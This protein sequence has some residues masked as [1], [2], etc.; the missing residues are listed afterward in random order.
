MNPFEILGIT[1]NATSEQIKKAFMQKAREKFPGAD[2]DDPAATEEYNKVIEAYKMLSDP[3]LRP[4]DDAEFSDEWTEETYFSESV[5]QLDGTY[6][7]D[8]G[9]ANGTV[10]NEEQVT[11]ADGKIKKKKTERKPLSPKKKKVIIIIVVGLALLGI[12]LAFF[13]TPRSLEINDGNKINTTVGTKS[14]LSVNGK[15][16]T[17]NDIKNVEW[18]VKNDSYKDNREIISIKNGEMTAL[19]AG[20]AN[21]V[22]KLSKGMFHYE[23]TLKVHI[24]YNKI[25]VNDGED[26]EMYS[27]DDVSMIPVK[28]E[29]L[30]PEQCKKIEWTSEDE[31]SVVIKCGKLE[32]VGDGSGFLTCKY[33][34]GLKKWAGECYIDVEY[35]PVEFENGEMVIDA[36]GDAP[37]EVTNES[38]GDAYVYFKSK[39]GDNDF[40]F[41]VSIDETAEVDAPCDTYEIY[42]A[43]GMDEWFGEKYLFGDDTE[44]YKWDDSVKFY[45][46]A[47]YVHGTQFELPNDA[48][49]YSN[50]NKISMKKFPRE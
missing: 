24:E 31:T 17:K 9:I 4:I 8:N 16:F 2:V 21:I 3:N 6:D 22:A 48:D 15:N 39:S 30:T 23:G 11:A 37:V 7:E 32:K 38:Y 44:C 33:S 29:G 41:L 28:A 47:E 25:I 10:K 42:Y 1:P 36:G 35:R 5:T 50:I 18:S 27:G 40:S 49:K 12:I 19:E 13:L 46:D 45:R 26:L 14:Y 43:V 20:D 34:D